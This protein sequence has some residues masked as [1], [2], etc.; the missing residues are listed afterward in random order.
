M[1]AQELKIFRFFYCILYNILIFNA[2]K[3]K[4]N[5]YIY[6]MS[7]FLA[8]ISLH[9]NAQ[10]RCGFDAYREH[11]VENNPNLEDVF[12]EIDQRVEAYI[13]RNAT[14]EGTIT[15]PV[16]VHLIYK[17]SSNLIPHEQV[18][19][20]LRVLNEDY[21]RRNTDTA[22]TPAAYK[23][24]AANT[25]IQFCL[26]S[27]DPDGN[28]TNGIT[29]TKTTVDKFTDDKVKFAASGGANAWPANEYLNIWVCKLDNQLLGYASPPGTPP[30]NDGVVVGYN[31][32]GSIVDDNGKFKL[33][34]TYK[35][36]RTVT[37]EVGH[38]LNLHHLWGADNGSCGTDKVADTPTQQNPHFQCPS[39]P[40][41]SCGNGPNGDMFMNFMD[42]TDDLCMNLFTKGQTSR[43]IAS[44]TTARQDLLT[45]SGCRGSI[46]HVSDQTHEIHFKAY[47]NPVNDK[48]MIDVAQSK[49]KPTTLTI[50]TLSG[51]PLKRLKL[52]SASQIVKTIDVSSYPPG[53][54]LLRLQSGVNILHQKMVVQ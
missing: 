31:F 4:K 18:F 8:S 40:Q 25:R 32:F 13:D 43:M 50:A 34:S 36:G 16:V 52:G 41:V 10:N 42:Y 38:W 23:P 15:I 28:W 6:L 47:P 30:S 24:L 11:L 20:Q 12:T 46:N 5:T 54:Y 14:V 3:F 51:K 19:S 44:I 33:H 1:V 39:F 53:I 17:D 26:A 27:R 37:H 22:N 29:V 49:Q 35:Y 21:G 45:S 48:L 9:L 7:L 2:I